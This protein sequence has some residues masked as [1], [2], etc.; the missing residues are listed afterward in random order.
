M[1]TKISR[2]LPLVTI[3]LLIA[4]FFSFD[5]HHWLTLEKLAQHRDFLQKHVQES[6]LL[7]VLLFGL[8][9]IVVVAASL[10]GAALLSLAAG[11]LFGQWLGTGLVIIGATI[12]AVLLF[13]LVN[14][15]LGATLKSKAGP[16]FH[17]I[18]AGFQDNAISYMLFLRLIPIFPFFAVNVAGAMMGIRLSVF[19]VT[20]ALGILP[21]SF[22]FVSAG[23]GLDAVLETG[24]I[25][26]R[27]TQIAFIGLGLVSLIPIGYKMLSKR[28]RSS[29]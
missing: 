23:V 6:L 28:R 10:P 18:S 27:Q 7:S 19:S 15:T 2:F 21:G 1:T 8:L 11:F 24:E 17:K 22:V 5:G 16:W 12:G 29:D 3:V 9:Y 26:N 13:L 4:V 20:T 25:I 14:T